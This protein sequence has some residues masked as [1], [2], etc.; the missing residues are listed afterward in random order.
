[1]GARHGALPLALRRVQRHP[2]RPAAA[3]VGAG[4]AL[5]GVGRVLMTADGVGGVWTYALDL[6]C[7][8]RVHGIT[9]TIATMGPRLS[10]DQHGEA[11]RRGIDVREGDFAL[12]WMDDPWTDVDAAAGWLLALEDE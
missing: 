7:G 11:A 4:A 3:A 5:M 8:L 12:E 6:A 1:M 10:V 9:V 2:G